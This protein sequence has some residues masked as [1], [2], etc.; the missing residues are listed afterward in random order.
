V[1]E[2][3]AS[4]HYSSF[5]ARRFLRARRKGFVS[6][7]GVFS[8]LGFAVGVASLIIVLA[9]MTGFQQDFI[10]RILGAN[11][12][13]LVFPADGSETIR[14]P[15]AVIARVEGVPHV[16]AAAPVVSGP[17][18]IVGP[19]GAVRWTVTSGVE[20][21]RIDEVTKIAE[22]MHFGSFDALDQPTVSGRPGIVLGDDLA[23]RL[24]AYPGDA[25]RMMIPRPR[26]TPWGPSIRQP[27]LEV[28]GTFRTGYHEYD[29][30]WSFIALGEAREFYGAGEGA[31]RVAVRL[32]DLQALDAAMADVAETL[33]PDYMVRSIVEI[34]RAY[35]SALKIEKLMMSFA[36]GLIV[37]V[38]ALGVVSTLVLTVTQKVREIGVL[39]ALGATR[40]GVLRVFVFQGLAMGFLGTLLGAVLGVGLCVG[41][42]RTQAISLDP[43]VYY[44]DHL[45][46]EVLPGDLFVVLGLSLVVALI[47][48]L[49]PAWRAASLDPVE[50]LRGD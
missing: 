37:V 11:A 3:K 13:I 42:D 28:V 44:L 10:G 27:A 18:G 7:I 2:P 5:L 36:L 35:F 26:I 38:A 41:L 46:F 31:H 50:A 29:T 40:R 23:S 47:A 21:A 43:E 15:E 6:L 8:A 33:G 25:V 9:L 24:G 48:T 45:P 14:D 19:N 49:Y 34:N 32:D 1:K 20:P 30:S 39:V 16:V 22:S 17:A 4:G 12:H